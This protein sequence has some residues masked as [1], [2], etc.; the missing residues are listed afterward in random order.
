MPTVKSGWKKIGF[1]PQIALGFY[2]APGLRKGIVM[3]T[4]T[5]K[6]V[7]I[8][9]FGA[10]ATVLMWFPKFPLFPVVPMLSYDFSDVPVLIGT[11][12]LGPVAGVFIAIVKNVLYFLT[13]SR[14]GLIGTFMNWSSTTAFLLVAGVFYHYVKKDRIGAAV[15]MVLGTA[16]FTCVAVLLNIHVALPMWGI[17]T[18]QIAPLVTTGIIPFNLAR[19]GISTIATLLLYRRT[20][21]VVRKHLRV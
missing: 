18:E 12:S 19:G 1:L 3:K 20:A 11:F 10:L 17:P 16:V 2:F 14:S 8:A 13:R 21:D 7:A 9:F 15:G 4:S 6:I 5:R